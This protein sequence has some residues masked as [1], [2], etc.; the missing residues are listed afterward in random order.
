MARRKTQ[1]TEVERLHNLLLEK[2]GIDPTDWEEN[3]HRKIAG[4]VVVKNPEVI[5]DIYDVYR[6]KEVDTE[7]EAFLEVKE[8]GQKGGP[9]PSTNHIS[10][11]VKK[12]ESAF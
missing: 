3:T 11:N 12:D 9:I 4:D 6:K 5:E 10:D 8:E 7:L 2:K 1:Q